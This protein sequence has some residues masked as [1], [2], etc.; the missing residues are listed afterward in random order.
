MIT[1]KQ[2]KLSNLRKLYMFPFFKL[3]LVGCQPGFQQQIEPYCLHLVIMM[4]KK[5]NTC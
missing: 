5:N 3:K 4:V 1:N 2:K